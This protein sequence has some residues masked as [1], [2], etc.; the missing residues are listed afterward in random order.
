MSKTQGGAF[1]AASADVA[2]QAG[3]KS[4]LDDLAARIFCE[5][6]AATGAFKQCLEHA[7]R[8]GELLIEAKGKVGHG[9]WLAWLRDNCQV[10]ERAAQNYMALARAKEDFKS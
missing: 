1:E 5:H 8:C 7:V 6:Q 4:D 2:H 3:G 9:G 10:K